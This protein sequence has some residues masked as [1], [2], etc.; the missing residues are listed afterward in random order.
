MKIGVIMFPTDNA[1][2]PMELAQACEERGF[3]SLWFP[4]HSHIPASRETPWGGREGAPPLPEEY[5]RSHDQFVG[6]A[7]AAAVTENL[8]VATGIC[9]VAQRDPIHTAKEVASLDQLSKGR[10]LFGIGGGWNLEEMQ[11]HGTS[12]DTRFKLMRERIEAMKRLWTEEKAEYHGDH[13]DFGPA[14]T[15][16]K[17]VQRPHPPIHVGGAGLRAIRRAVR[18]GDGWIPLMGSGDDDPVALLPQLREQL[19]SIETELRAVIDDLAS[20]L[21]Y[22]RRGESKE[23]RFED[24]GESRRSRVLIRGIEGIEHRLKVVCADNLATYVDKYWSAGYEP[25]AGSAMLVGVALAGPAGTSLALWWL[26]RE[27]GRVRR[28]RKAD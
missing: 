25:G 15:W 24:D 5:W 4:E 13:V 7:A 2:Q 18:Y 6:L 8:K 16:P 14:Y 1:I 26:W 3:E 9:L 27:V 17:P 20:Y 23:I 10:F 22:Q 11:N 12:P 19:P 28:K 21:E